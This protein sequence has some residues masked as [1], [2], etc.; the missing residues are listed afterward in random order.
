MKEYLAISLI[1]FWLFF[2]VGMILMQ[3]NEYVV[4]D[5]GDINDIEPPENYN[6]FTAGKEVFNFIKLYFII[7]IGVIP[8][9]PAF[10]N[11]ILIGLKLISVLTIYLLLRG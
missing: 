5:T 10:I 6:I 1:L 8:N 4:L 2:P 3:S 7:L 11:L 9:A